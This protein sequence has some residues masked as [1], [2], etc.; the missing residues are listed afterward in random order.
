MPG[1]RYR[2]AHSGMSAP[3]AAAAVAAGA[4]EAGLGMGRRR[5]GDRTGLGNISSL[6][7][8]KRAA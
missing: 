1:A 7:S 2:D 4:Y 5:M 3:S 8:A 6:C